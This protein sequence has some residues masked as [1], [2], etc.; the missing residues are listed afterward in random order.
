MSRILLEPDIAGVDG[1]RRLSPAGCWARKVGAMHPGV[2]A[3]IIGT[4]LFVG[5]AGALLATIL[6]YGTPAGQGNLYWVFLLGAFAILLLLSGPAYAVLSFP[7]I[8]QWIGLRFGRGALLITVFAAS[9]A[10]SVLSGAALIAMAATRT[11]HPHMVAL[12]IGATAAL[13]G[14][15]RY[16]AR[17]RAGSPPRAGDEKA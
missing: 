6:L 5:G 9:M 4:V 16:I 3:L 8:L 17:D 10:M 1:R 7:L 15:L 11:F 14:F 12:L 2:R 13:W